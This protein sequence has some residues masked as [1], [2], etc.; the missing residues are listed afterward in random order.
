M[1]AVRD[2]GADLGLDVVT[3]DRDAGLGELVRPLLGAG[4]E[5][6]EG[7][8]EGDLGVD[9]ALGVELRRVLGADGQVADQD[10]DLLVLEDLDD[11]DRGLGGLLDG[12]AVVLAQAVEGVAA[13]HGD[14]G[15]R[16]VADLDGVV[17]AGAD[18][19]REVEADLLRVDVEGGDELDVTHVVVAELDVHQ[20]GHLGCRVGVLVVLDALHQRGGAVAHADDGY[21]NR[22]HSGCS[23]CVSSEAAD[24]G[25]TWRCR[26]TDPARGCPRCR[27]RPPVSPDV[28]S[29]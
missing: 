12:L 9:G 18:G 26:R 29:C 22:T 10:V 6:R 8:D 1:H 23:L 4:D 7:V 19:V 15:R 14:A 28:V 2:G 27:G 24:V 17:L 5:D 11:V 13:L 21:A 20:A 3:D 16:H 25:L